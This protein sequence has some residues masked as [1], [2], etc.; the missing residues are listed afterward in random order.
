MAGQGAEAARGRAT[1]TRPRREIM[2]LTTPGNS[3]QPAP[4]WVRALFNAVAMLERCFSRRLVCF[5]RPPQSEP[6]PSAGAILAPSAASAEL[7]QDASKLGARSTASSPPPLHAWGAARPMST[8]R[9]PE[10]DVQSKQARG[11]LVDGA[12]G[13][14]RPSPSIFGHS[15]SRNGA[16]SLPS[17]RSKPTPPSRR[18]PLG[19]GGKQDTSREDLIRANRW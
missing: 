8:L 5:F 2:E 6:N 7:P 19:W 11:R 18:A 3:Q 1:E 15:R 14:W 10:Q 9:I 12:K 17:R 4:R 13:R 16:G